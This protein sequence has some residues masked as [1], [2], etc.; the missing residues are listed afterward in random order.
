MEPRGSLH[1]AWWSL[2]LTQCIRTVRGQRGDRDLN[3][4]VD[5]VKWMGSGD[6]WE[7]ES[8]LGWWDVGPGLEPLPLIG[9]QDAF[10][11]TLSDCNTYLCFVTEEIKPMRTRGHSRKRARVKTVGKCDPFSRS[12]FSRLGQKSPSHQPSIPRP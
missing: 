9:S 12:A 8:T 3:R 10:P 2:Y 11:A 6:V 4:A 1:R 7:T 5:M